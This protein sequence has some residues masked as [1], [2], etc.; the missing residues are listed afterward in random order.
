M[1]VLVVKG[2]TKILLARVKK[3]EKCMTKEE[4]MINCWKPG[5]ND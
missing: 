4:D 5:R 1:K 2:E 3:F